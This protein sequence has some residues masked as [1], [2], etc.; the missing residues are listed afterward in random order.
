MAD[1]LPERLAELEKSVKQAVEV[2]AGLRRERDALG[3]KLTAME[4]ERRELQSLKQ[5]RKDVLAQV[6]SI[7]KE[8][9]KLDL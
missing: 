5:E 6:D 7:L 3:A 4:A 2:I 8:L 9:D 1:N